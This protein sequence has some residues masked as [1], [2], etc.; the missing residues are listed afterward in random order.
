VPGLLLLLG[1]EPN[2]LIFQ[3]M[4]LHKTD[5][6]LGHAVALMG[7]LGTIIGWHLRL[8]LFEV[9]LRHLR[10]IKLSMPGSISHASI[11]A[12]IIGVLA[13]TVFV[14]SHAS[15]EEAIYTGE[16]R[17]SEIQVGTGKFFYL[18]LMLIASSVVFSGYLGEKGRAWWIV[19]FPSLMAAGAFFVLGGRARAFVPIAAAI[20]V[21]RYRRDDSIISAKVVF[22]LGLLLLIAFSYVGQIYRGSGVEG[23]EELWSLTS[24]AEYLE[25]ATWIDWG[26]LHALAGAVAIGPGV[27]EGQT[28]LSM[29]W[30]VNKIITLPMRSAGVFI[31]DTLVPSSEHKWSFHPTL[32]GDAYLNFGLTGVFVVTIMFG[33]ILKGL[34]VEKSVRPMNNAIYALSLVYAFRIFFESIEKFG[35]MLVVLVFAC[36]VI[37]CSRILEVLYRS[38]GAV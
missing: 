37:H 8:R 35:E 5:W 36:V 20:L 25:Y 30:P 17:R 31:V 27:L 2:Q 3:V 32:I 22:P 38:R 21:L 33:T 29:L 4:G 1:V 28:F 16:L 14:G 7:I 18:S 26:Q 6:D 24:L 13:L 11:A 12:M 19:L 9:T 10:I 15:V 23:V 34:Y